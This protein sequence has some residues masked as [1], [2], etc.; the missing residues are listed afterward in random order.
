MEPDEFIRFA[1]SISNS[2]KTGSAGSA[3]TF[4]TAVHIG[5]EYPSLTP[6]KD[7]GDAIAG[8]ELGRKLCKK[9]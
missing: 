5:A 2:K 3:K 7:D 6:P 1:E 9:T 8:Y 4:F